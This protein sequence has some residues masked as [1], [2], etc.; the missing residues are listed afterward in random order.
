MNAADASGADGKKTIAY[1][2]AAGTFK[3]SE[4]RSLKVDKAGVEEKTSELSPDKKER[5]RA[6]LS[7][8]QEKFGWHPLHLVEEENRLEDI[9]PGKGKPERRENT[10]RYIFDSIPEL[11]EF[12]RSDG[13]IRQALHQDM[14]NAVVG[15]RWFMD[16]ALEE[17]RKAGHENPEEH[18]EHLQKA[19]AVEFGKLLGKKN[20]P[21]NGFPMKAE[22]ARTDAVKAALAALR[23][24]K[25]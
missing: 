6:I 21:L 19:G 1:M 16:H 14:V 8:V 18:A 7:E 20:L 10:H 13:K 12:L 3:T 22:K 4:P 17:A 25:E 24:K 5:L 15:S 9:E 11:E 23:A 2:H